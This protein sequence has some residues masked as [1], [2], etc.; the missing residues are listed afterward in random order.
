MRA[1][2]QTFEDG[3]KA[4]DTAARDRV[5]WRG[6]TQHTTDT[7]LP[8]MLATHHEVTRAAD[9]RE[10]SSS[11]LADGKRPFEGN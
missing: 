11:D 5:T 4:R 9:R 7:L 1:A 2:L 10:G 6:S 3:A 8:C